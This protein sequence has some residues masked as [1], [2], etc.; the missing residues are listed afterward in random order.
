MWRHEKG[1]CLM[2]I[3]H[4]RNLAPSTIRTVILNGETIKASGE[5]ATLDSALRVTFGRDHVM[6][7][8]L[9]V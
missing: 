8:L 6:E 2:D 5:S 1:E 7:K 9:S 3:S 4:A